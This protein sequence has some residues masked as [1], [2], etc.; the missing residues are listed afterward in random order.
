MRARL[1]L[2]LAQKTVLL[3]DV[4]LNNKPVEMLAASCKEKGKVTVPL[5]VFEQGEVIDESLDIML[6]ALHEN[7]PQQLLCPD[8]PQALPLMLA[9]I[10]R[11]DHDF[12]AQLKQYKAAARY[13]DASQEYCRRQC[14]PFIA[15]LEQRLTASAFFF[16][17]R[18]SLA[19]YALLPFIRQFARVDRQW[20]IKAPYPNLQR[21]LNS[22]LQ[23]A[24]FTKVLA[25][26][27]LWL[28]KR[29]E[30]LFGG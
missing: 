12:I 3:R 19:D 17:E 21:W 5:L 2:L 28:D 24:I 4:V 13:K 29:E 23:S 16:G 10:Q 25:K 1:A 11:N 27:P 6:W 8:D 30:R 14:E 18:A 20:Y 7:D 26:Y 15:E 22:Q 9:L